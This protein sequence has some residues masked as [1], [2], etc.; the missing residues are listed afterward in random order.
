MISA[1]SRILVLTP[2]PD[3]EVVGACAMMARARAKGAKIFVLPLTH[4]CVA[5]EVLWFWERSHHDAFVARRGSE[6]RQVADLLG[7]TVVGGAQRAARQAWRDLA[8]VAVEIRAAIAEHGITEI[9]TPAYEG[10]NADHDAI[11]ACAAKIQKETG[12]EVIEFAEYNFNQGK[13]NAQ[14]FPDPNGSETVIELTPAE[15]ELKRKALGL[16]ASEQK[17]LFYVGTTQE[18][19]RPL[20][21]YDY[22]KPAHQGVLWYTRF[23]WVPFRHPRIDF[24]T[25]TEVS[26]AI[27]TFLSTTP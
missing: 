18:C 5:R 17:N 26:A 7:F 14:T 2:H 13:T 8:N 22:T 3:D 15:Q 16:Y 12:L 6:L 11:N 23:H 25:P 20:A 24:S 19:F 9:W 1:K 27:Q 4:G 10:G 21:L